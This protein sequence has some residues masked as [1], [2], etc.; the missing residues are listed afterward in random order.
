LIE[1]L[2]KLLNPKGVL[3]ISD[4]RDKY[5][6]PSVHFMEWVGDWN[7]VYRDDESFREIF[8]KA[9]YDREDLEPRYEQQGILQYIIAT[10]KK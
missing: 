6:N 2:R 1:N 4:V 3:L 7:L 8:Y 10:E 5:S 9:G